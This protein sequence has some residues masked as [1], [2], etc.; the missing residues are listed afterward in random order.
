MKKLSL[1]VPGGESKPFG[2][3]V[4]SLRPSTLEDIHLIEYHL[5]YSWTV[6]DCDSS[7]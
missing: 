7:P 3:I 5:D 1:R 6:D 4:H 2:S